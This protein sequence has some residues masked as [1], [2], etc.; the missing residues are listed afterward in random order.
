MKKILDA[1]PGCKTYLVA[2]LMGIAVFGVWQKWWVIPNDI[3]AAAVA[4][5]AVFIRAGI[6]R[7]I[8]GLASAPTLT[9]NPPVNNS[10]QARP[11]TGVSGP[12]GLLACGGLMLLATGCMSTAIKDGYIVSVKQRAFGLIVETASTQ[13]GSPNI[14]LGFASTVVQMIPTAT[15]E[16]HAPKFVDSFDIQQSINPFDTSISENAGSGDVVVGA[17]DYGLSGA[18]TPS[19]VPWAQMPPGASNTFSA[20]APYA[21]GTNAPFSALP[22]AS[23][24]TNAAST[25]K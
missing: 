8:A 2:M 21:T 19:A 15:N 9:L 23:A 11:S 4:L 22:P 14:K 5:L 12:L 7:E 13:N 18:I 1:L 6:T 24:G 3:Y 20:L 17:T 10:P 25:A 16:L